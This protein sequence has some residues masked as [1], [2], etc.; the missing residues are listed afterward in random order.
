VLWAIESIK[1]N[2]HSVFEQSILLVYSNQ[3]WSHS[4]IMVNLICAEPENMESGYRRASVYMQK[5]H[6]KST[7]L[8]PQQKFRNACCPGISLAF[9][10]D[11]SVEWTKRCRFCEVRD[12]SLVLAQRVP[13]FQLR[14]GGQAPPRATTIHTLKLHFCYICQ[15]H[16]FT[17]QH[18][19]LQLLATLHHSRLPPTTAVPCDASTMSDDDDFMQD[20]GEEE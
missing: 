9:R 8:P 12:S 4:W 1:G 14:G 2:E 7:M 5:N 13:P 20:S 3:T 17:E 6:C 16:F 10:F 11:H 18:L 15:P 19:Y